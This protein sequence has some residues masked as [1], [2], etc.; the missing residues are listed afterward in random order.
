MPSCG[1]IFQDRIFFFGGSFD[2]QTVP[3]MAIYDSPSRLVVQND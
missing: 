1:D 2:K 3:P